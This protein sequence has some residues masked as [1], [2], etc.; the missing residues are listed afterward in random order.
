MACGA[1]LLA[2]S[3]AQAQF[4]NMQGPDHVYIAVP[5]KIEVTLDCPPPGEAPP[6]L[7]CNGSTL[8]FFDVSDPTA[9]APDDWIVLQPNLT[10]SA[11]PFV[12]HRSGQNYIQLLTEDAD[13]VGAIGFVV[14]APRGRL[15]GR[16][17]VISEPVSSP[18]A[19]R[20]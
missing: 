19:P 11:G 2:A 20:R 15:H 4:A 10:V 9:F 1:L 14:Q 5:F 7:R 6:P 8:A 13:F 17:E 18:T 12:F 16:G 3:G